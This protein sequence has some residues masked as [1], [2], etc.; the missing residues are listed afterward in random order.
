MK[1]KKESQ[2]ENAEQEN[3][4][5]TACAAAY[6]AACDDAEAPPPLDLRESK[7][8]VR[9][10]FTMAQ[11]VELGL[12]AARQQSSLA[13]L[14]AELASIKGEYKTKITAAENDRN[15]AMNKQRDGFEMIEVQAVTRF[16]H[17]KKGRKTIYLA[18]LEKPNKIGEPIREED[19]GDSDRQ[20]VMRLEEEREAVKGKDAA[21]PNPVVPP[22]AVK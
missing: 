21:L 2:K 8:R 10:T 14:E 16:N 19:M 20:M 3:D 11:M 7:E 9:Y 6:A 18:D 17:P 1:T 12:F 13:G 4:Y 22:N 5:D 15:L